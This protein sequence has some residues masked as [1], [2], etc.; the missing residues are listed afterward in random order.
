M[1]IILFHRHTL[2]HACARKHMRARTHTQI[3]CVSQGATE[4]GTHI[5]C[6]ALRNEDTRVPSKVRSKICQLLKYPQRA[7]SKYIT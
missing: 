2:T 7:V 6:C 5:Y 3:H 1:A 4:G